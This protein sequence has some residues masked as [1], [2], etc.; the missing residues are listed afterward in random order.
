MLDVPDA[1]ELWAAVN[2]TVLESAFDAVMDNAVKFTPDDTPIEVTAQPEGAMVH[3]RV[4]DHGAGVPPEELDRMT[5]RFWRSP[6]HHM[7]RGSGLGLAICSEL[8]ALGG[9]DLKLS[10]PAGGGLQAT[11]G[12]PRWQES[13]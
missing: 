11:I 10:L 12:V 1:E 2:R 7:V 5:E 4:R 3:V 13:T 6:A 9:G 8:L